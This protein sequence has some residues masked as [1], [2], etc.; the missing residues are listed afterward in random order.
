[1]TTYLWT[2]SLI[3]YPY[4][5]LFVELTHRLTYKQEF[6]KTTK[7]CVGYEPLCG[8]CRD[9]VSRIT[10]GQNN[11][12]DAEQRLLSMSSMASF[13]SDLPHDAEK[14]WFRQQF[15]SYIEIFNPD[16]P[17]QIVATTRYN[18]SFLEAA[19]VAREYIPAGKPISFLVGKTLRLSKEKEKSLTESGKDFSV[20][21][22][23]YRNSVSILLGPARF[24]NHDCLP[25]CQLVPSKSRTIFVRAMCNIKAG[26]EITVF[27][28][29]DYFGDENSECLC[30]TCKNE[31][32]DVINEYGPIYGKL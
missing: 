10:S 9:T 28:S 11:T 21:E 1:M 16:C 23:S 3:V 4:A 17:F 5:P 30:A 6:F 22:S 2:S 15:R 27:Y 12:K 20:V 18:P 19:V 14:K 32:A 7:S 13:L 26:E 31:E 8:V 29:G 24:V 25:N